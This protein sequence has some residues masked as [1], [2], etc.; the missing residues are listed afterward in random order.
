MR[1]CILYIIYIY[2]RSLKRNIPMLRV[3]KTLKFININ[4]IL[5]QM[6]SDSIE[7]NKKYLIEKTMDRRRR[8]DEMLNEIPL[9]QR[10]DI[11]C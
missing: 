8:E 4:I 10:H 3:S 9:L 7:I 5:Y 2:V 1:V 6:R 11:C